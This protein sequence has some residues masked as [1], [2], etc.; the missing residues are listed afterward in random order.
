MN[1]HEF[2]MNY[3]ELPMRS[4]LLCQAKH[5]I[6]LSGDALLARMCNPLNV[7]KK[8]AHLIDNKKKILNLQ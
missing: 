2:S 4:A 6:V 1:Y 8:C 7:V 3:H 5:H